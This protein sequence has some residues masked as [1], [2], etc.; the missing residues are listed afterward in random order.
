MKSRLAIFAMYDAD[1]LADACIL[2]MLNEMN[3]YVKDLIVVCNCEMRQESLD[4]LKDYASDIQINLNGGFDSGAYKQAIDKLGW[5]I[6]QQYDELILFNDSNYG[7]IY[8]LGGM[9]EKMDN[10]PCDFW[11]LTYQDAYY[12]KRSGGTTPAH[13]RSDFYV[14]RNSVLRNNSF[15]EYW[16]NLRLAKS[17]LDAVSVYEFALSKL[18]LSLDFRGRSYVEPSPATIPVSIFTDYKYIIASKNPFIKKKVF[19]LALNV[20][21]CETDTHAAIKVFEHIKRNTSFDENLILKHL[22]RICDMSDFRNIFGLTYVFSENYCAKQDVL[23]GKKVGIILHINYDDLFEHCFEYIR[24]IPECI[25]VIITTKG[26]ANKC[27]I[28]SLF[29]SIQRRNYQIIE[30]LDRGRE[31]SGRLIACKTFLMQYDYLCCT[32]D[33]KSNRDIDS[34]AFGQTFMDLLWDNSVA[35]GEYIKNVIDCFERN[36][37]LGLLVTPPPYHG[38]YCVVGNLRWCGEFENT[39]ALAERIGIKCR[40]SEEKTPLAVGGTFWCRTAA[41]KP[42]FTYPWSYEDFPAE[43]MPV[44]G[45]ISHAIERIY[46]YVAQYEGYFTSV[47]MSDRYAG[48]SITTYQAMFETIV[49][50]LFESMGQNFLTYSELLN[51]T[52]HSGLEFARFVLQNKR[53]YLYGA[54]LFGSYIQKVLETSGIQPTAFVVSDGHKSDPV[55]NNLPVYELSEIPRELDCGVLITVGRALNHIM[56]EALNKKGITNYYSFYRA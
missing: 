24:E 44:N 2:Y 36:P 22:I 5:D 10:T 50:N 35:S 32:Q 41:L 31:L 38:D 30:P 14:F 33:K 18:L 9:F 25:D 19:T 40:I 42:L 29:E 26:E 27:R 43:P 1:G 17:Y 8:P 46:P 7:P 45:T 51:T 6:V 28:K 15:R 39:K 4:K 3:R 34:N 12:D 16:A 23:K 20:K 37:L 56:I 48:V 54:G 21:L 55:V 53:L 11:T 49:Q 52:T 13:Y 47:M